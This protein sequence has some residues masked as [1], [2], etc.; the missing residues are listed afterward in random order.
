MTTKEKHEFILELVRNA[1]I[2][3]NTYNVLYEYLKKEE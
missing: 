1:Q 3:A 2:G